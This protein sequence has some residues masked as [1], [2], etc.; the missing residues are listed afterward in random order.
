MNKSSNTGKKSWLRY[1]Y[2]RWIEFEF[3][4]RYIKKPRMDPPH[5]AVDMADVW[6]ELKA[7]R[8]AAKEQATV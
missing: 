5:L 2:L 3:L 7:K 4:Q 8:Y 1:G 6:A